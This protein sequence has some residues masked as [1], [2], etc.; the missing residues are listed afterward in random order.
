MGFNEYHS[1]IMN[2]ITDVVLVSIE[3]LPSDTLKSK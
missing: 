1:Q 3:A 2:D